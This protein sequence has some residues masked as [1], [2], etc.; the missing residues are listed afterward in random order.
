MPRRYRMV[1][2][3]S[4]TK[5][6]IKEYNKRYYEETKKKNPEYK[7]LIGDL[8]YIAENY[9]EFNFVKQ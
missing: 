3:H 9:M 5:E 8:K 7:E 1:N 6:D 2:R 4:R